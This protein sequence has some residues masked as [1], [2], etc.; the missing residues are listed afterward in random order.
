MREIDEATATAF[1]LQNRLDMCRGDAQS[2]LFKEADFEQV[3]GEIDAYCVTLKDKLFVPKWLVHSM[4]RTS[5][6]L[7]AEAAMHGDKSER[8]VA[9]TRKMDA[10]VEAILTDRT[11]A[12]LYAPLP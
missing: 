9:M 7:R 5:R 2:G 10:L 1:A 6:A 3:I 4:M 12:D 11:L 8:V